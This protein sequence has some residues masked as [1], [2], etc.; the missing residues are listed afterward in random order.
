MSKAWSL[1]LLTSSL[2]AMENL[3]GIP[4]PAPRYFPWLEDPPPYQAPRETKT[5]QTIPAPKSTAIS[6]SVSIYGSQIWYDGDT[7][8]DQARMAGVY[9]GLT[10]PRLGT[11]EAD[12]E[13]LKLEF[14]TGL[15]IEQS[16]ATLMFSRWCMEESLQVRLGAHG[17]HDDEHGWQ[18]GQTA[19]AGLWWAPDPR[20]KLGSDAFSSRFTVTTPTL[21]A[22]QATPGF[23]WR[24]WQGTNWT[25][26]QECA[27][28]AIHLD[29]EIG[30][31]QTDY[32]AG[33][34]RLRLSW[35]PLWLT[36]EA[37]TGERAYAVGATGFAVYDVPALYKNGATCTLG[38][39][40][41]SW[42]SLSLTA[43]R[44]TFQ[45][46]W[47]QGDAHSKSLLVSLGFTF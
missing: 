2:A 14:S 16:D 33:E 15:E 42:A 32:Y 10:M 3:G 22:I 20:F 8:R 40:V 27:F 31:Y 39:A 29:Q 35:A 24:W 11:F 37:W 12:F 36:A 41:G 25:L 4:A 18:A 26:S 34:S 1:F 43:S 23:A 38:C 45:H 21:R 30:F 13:Q 5:P 44:D 47:A 9:L 6:S 19:I 7:S 17:I 28:T 46:P